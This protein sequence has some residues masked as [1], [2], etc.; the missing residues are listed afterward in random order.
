MKKLIKTLFFKL[1]KK[2]LTFYSIASIVYLAPLT[3]SARAEIIYV[4]SNYP[5]ISS[6]IHA[7]TDGDTVLIEKGTYSIGSFVIR[8]KKITLAST[9]IFTRNEADIDET[10][11]KGTGS[12]IFL[13]KGSKVSGS[14]VIGLTFRDT[15]HMIDIED[16]AFVHVLR[17]KFFGGKD[18]LS[19]NY[20]GGYI[21]HCYFTE[22]SDD[23]IDAD[24]SKNWT[25]EYCELVN[26]GDDGIEVRLH[27]DTLP[28]KT[29]II[30]Y[31]YISGSDEDGIQLI[32]YSKDSH[33]EFYIHHNVIVNNKQAG[34][35]CMAGGKTD[36]NFLG[37]PMVEPAYIYNNTIIGNACGISGAPNMLVINNIISK[38]GS[39]GGLRNIDGNSVVDYCVLNNNSGGNYVGSVNQ[40]SSNLIQDPLLRTN[41]TLED[42]SPCID[43]GIEYYSYGRLSLAVPER[44][45]NGNAPDI[46]AYEYE[47]SMP[48]VSKHLV[49]ELPQ[50]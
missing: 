29:H 2:V 6:A 18:Q 27:A 44:E 50:N 41:W 40:G 12:S 36:E 7:A 11:I 33:R 47:S 17:C 19:F 26:A 22:S 42:E 48:V 45:F 30:R 49:M 35:G 32:D 39:Y 14:R 21:A 13:F 31:N 46:G 1:D 37:S 23:G 20:G 38:N 34:I 25:V 28:V 16:G 9:Y 8:S 15:A 43:S 10:V 3:T 5:S 24:H 4:P